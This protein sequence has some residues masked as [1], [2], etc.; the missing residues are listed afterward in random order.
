MVDE[1]RRGPLAGLRILDTGRLVAGP[2]AATLAA[3]FGA[4]VIHVEPPDGEYMRLAQEIWA[5]ESRNKL[6]LAADLKKEA[7]REIFRRLVRVSDI[8][9]ESSKPGTYDALGLDDETVHDLN[10]RL[11]IVHV[12]G[13]G[14]RGNPEDLRR[15]AV[16]PI[17]Q[18]FSGM[19]ALNGFP[20]PNLPVLARP[21]ISDYLTAHCA[22]W[23]ALIGYIHALKTGQGQSIDV[24]MYEAILRMLGEIA[25]SYF[26]EGVVEGRRGNRHKW[27]APWD[28]YSSKDGVLFFVTA[29][30][31]HFARLCEAIGENPSDPLWFPQFPNCIPD[32][33]GERELEK[34][35]RRWI[36]DHTAAE[37][38]D[39]LIRRFG[40]PCQRIQTIADLASH[41]HCR[42]RENFVT[43][44]DPALGSVRGPG[45]VPCFSL[46][47]GEV[48]RGAPLLGQD[49]DEILRD[50][51]YNSNEIVR[52]LDEGVVGI[53]S[54]PSP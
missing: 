5:V 14:Q 16:D 43:W 19:M 41:P 53:A 50:L 13:F 33:P 47:P 1:P 35:L 21:M 38:E 30:G 54:Q 51:G 7:G 20:E 31:D 10:P 8:W 18:A 3:E 17:I 23:A 15:P 24:A 37:I 45:V 27:A 44:N 26:R 22:L 39:I 28:T 52:L 2:F 29:L 40:I 4:R 46:T 11:V 25:V 32:T 34:K 12:S 49:T 6:S 42:A 48:W 9:I 36:G